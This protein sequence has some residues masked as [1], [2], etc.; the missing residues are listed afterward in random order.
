MRESKLAPTNS[1][2]SLVLKAR[3]MWKLLPK[4]TICKYNYPDRAKNTGDIM[5]QSP[6]PFTA[7]KDTV[8]LP[9]HDSHNTMR[10]RTVQ[11]LPVPRW[12][13]RHSCC[14]V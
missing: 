13:C 11:S 5:K 12:L 7:H 14:I 9:L 6:H 2:R 1:V 8:A 3:T 10:S 4:D